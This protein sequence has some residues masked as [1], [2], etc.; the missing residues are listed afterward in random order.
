[1]A[2]TA[3]TSSEIGSTA[4]GIS[5]GSWQIP[6]GPFTINADDILILSGG[7]AYPPGD[8]RTVALRPSAN[9]THVTPTHFTHNDGTA[10]D[11]AS[12]S[13]LDDT[14]FGADMLYVTQVTAN[15]GSMLGFQIE[16]TA[17]SC[18]NAVWGLVGHT[19]PGVWNGTTAVVDGGTTRVF[20][21]AS[22]T[23][24]QIHSGLIAPATSWSTAA[25]NGMTFRVGG[26]TS[27]DR[28]IWHALMVEVDAAV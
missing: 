13:R 1:V 2:Q 5:L 18:I 9:G 8:G 15:S 21:S 4:T 11:P 23:G 27:V 6:S 26:S 28:P 10:I 14:P 7:A 12:W 24:D 17:E 19:S 25:V 20:H 3:A 16:D 22:F